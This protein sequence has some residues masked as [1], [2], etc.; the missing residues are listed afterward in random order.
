[1]KRVGVSVV[2][3]LMVWVPVFGQCLQTPQGTCWRPEAYNWTLRSGAVAQVSLP[4]PRHVIVSVPFRTP[5]SASGSI[6]S[7]QSNGL[8]LVFHAATIDV[9]ALAGGVWTKIVTLDGTEATARIFATYM[10]TR[11]AAEKGWWQDLK[12]AFYGGQYSA[13]E[14]CNLATLY[15]MAASMTLLGLSWAAPFSPTAFL[16]AFAAYADAYAKASKACPY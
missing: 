8:K 6:G 11:P 10:V 4:A 1:M 12:D 14:A 16:A 9:W 7:F 15:L 5:G 2:A 13:S 3:A